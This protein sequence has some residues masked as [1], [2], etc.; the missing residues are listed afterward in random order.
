[1][2]IVRP[3]RAVRYNT[4]KL[5]DIAKVIAPPYDVIPKD[6]QDRLYRASP[7]NIVR[8]ILNKITPK[9]TRSDNRYTRAK[10]LFDLWIRNNILIRD[11]RDSF[12]IYSQKYKD[13]GRP[14]EQI[15]FLGLMGL[16]T[17]GKDK[18]LPHENT[19]AAPK[20]DRLKL[21]REVRA[22]LEPIFV[23]YEDGKVTKLLKKCCS[24][25]KAV[26][27]VIWE[28]VRHRVW[29]LEDPG[30]IRA[31]ESNMKGKNIFIA[32]GHHRY[33]VAKMYA[34]ESGTDTSQYIMVYFVES[35]EKMLTV[36][37]AHRLIKEMNGLRKDDI[38]KRLNA[39]FH[40]EKVSGLKP[41][42][43]RLGSLRAAHAFAMYLG[44]KNLY[45]L[46][47]KNIEASDSVIKDKPEAWKHLDVSI[48]HLFIFQHVLGIRDDDENI[49]FL[50]DPAKAVE[51]VDSGKFKAAF[52]LNPTKVSE[53]K[54]I[55]KLGERMPRKSTYF[56]PKQ[57]SG[58]V[59]YKH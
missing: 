7:N 39:F 27:D 19:L 35:D 15:G 10:R 36:L 33:E 40:I 24:E 46:R 53:V 17:A 18:I 41:M 30:I 23:L 52:F 37:P 54:K 57:L 47:L 6:L 9:D 59:I 2:P 34:R 13:A 38:I 56:Y 22:N 12:Y 4:E 1:M 43:A 51:A 16:E 21:T 3:F 11:K 29:R 42:M 26:M 58:L 49:E 44:K 14:V 55:A 5:K 48:L 50:K 25:E 20:E 32:D 45:V 8:L 28:D 31:I